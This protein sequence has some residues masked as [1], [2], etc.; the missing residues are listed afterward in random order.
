[1]SAAVG[2]PEA[3]RRDVGVDLR[4]REALV[5]EELLDDAEIGAAFEKMGGERM[6]QRVRRDAER[7]PAVVQ[8][9]GGRRRGGVRRTGREDRPAA[10]EVRLERRPRRPAEQPDPLLPALPEDPQLAPAEVERPEIGGG[11]LTDPQ[12]G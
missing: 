4:R 10:E 11:Q 3:R 6:A 5:P 8:E 1:M 12:A 2:G 7:C 9:Q